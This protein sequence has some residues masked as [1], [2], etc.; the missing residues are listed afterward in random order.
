[1]PE[2]N[3]END[4]SLIYEGVRKLLDTLPGENNANEDEKEELIKELTKAF[5]E[6]ISSHTREH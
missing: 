6:L 2:N 3:I 5:H 4:N 1:M